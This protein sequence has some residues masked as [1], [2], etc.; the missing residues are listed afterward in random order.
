[1][2]SLFR[3]CVALVAIILVVAWLFGDGS[4]TNTTSDDGFNTRTMSTM[5][6]SQVILG[7]PGGQVALCTDEAAY[8]RLNQLSLA[9]DYDGIG[10]MVLMGQIHLMPGGTPALII[11]NGVFSHEV[12]ILS[13][14]HEGRYGLVSVNY[15]K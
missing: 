6:G 8:K 13:G 12:K 3:I 5:P 15:V 7:E 2:K 4:K 11:D 14:D 10:R 1:M 9:K